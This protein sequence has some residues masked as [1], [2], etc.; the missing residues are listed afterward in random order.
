MKEYRR[1]PVDYKSE[2]L[3]MRKA[4]PWHAVLMIHTDM[5][6]AKASLPRQPRFLPLEQLA[7]LVAAKHLPLEHCWLSN[8]PMGQGEKYI[9]RQEQICYANLNFRA[10]PF[11]WIS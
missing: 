1:S 3:I 9:S 10:S 6:Q 2:W 4:F 7:F 11:V 5:N 8:E